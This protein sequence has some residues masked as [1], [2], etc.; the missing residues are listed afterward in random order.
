MGG[1]GSGQM[2][3]GKVGWGSGEGKYTVFA[4]E[5]FS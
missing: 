2:G 1:R 3:R 4:I 5:I